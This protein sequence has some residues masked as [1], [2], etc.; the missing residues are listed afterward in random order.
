MAEESTTPDLVALARQAY[1]AY[2]REGITGILRY[3]APDVEWRNPTESPNAGVFI[4][5]KGVVEWQGM[6]DAAF[7]EM[8]FEPEWIDQLPPGQVLA[9][10][11]FRFRSPTSDVQLEV[12]FAHLMTWRDGKV[13][14]FRMYT[15]IDEAR[16]AA[17]RLARERG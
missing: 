1:V 3:L 10:V 8:H 5:H 14:R 16:T 13:T 11:R 6:V 2:N 9:S 17:E 15:D 4:G 12:P 7:K